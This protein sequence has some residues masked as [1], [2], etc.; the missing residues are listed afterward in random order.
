MECVGRQA[1]A[2][3]GV[4]QGGSVIPPCRILFC[5]G[6]DLFRFRWDVL[7]TVAPQR[8]PAGI[9]FVYRRKMASRL[10]RPMAMLPHRF[11]L[12]LRNRP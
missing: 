8:F 6:S 7:E 10:P 11:S 9:F 12:A 4:R 2:E 5:C 1:E 3:K